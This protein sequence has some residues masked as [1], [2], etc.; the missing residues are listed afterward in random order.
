MLKI[1]NKAL[2]VFNSYYA[3]QVLFTDDTKKIKEIDKKYLHTMEVVK[4]GSSVVKSL[5]FNETFV[6]L[7]KLAF[8]NHDIG[9]FEQMLITGNYI[10]SDLVAQIGLNHGELGKQIL[11]NGLIEKEIPS[12][13]VYDEPI[14]DIVDKHVDGRFDEKDLLVLSSDLLK[15][16][17]AIEFFSRASEEE[18]AKVINTITQIVQDVDRLD[19]YHQILEGRWTPMKVDEP[20]NPKV[21]DMFYNGEYLNMVELKKQGLWNANVGELVRL[22]FVNQIRLLSVAK[23]I[24]DKNI[25]MKMKELRQNP[26]VLDAFDFMQS[27]LEEMINNS[28]GITICKKNN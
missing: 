14:L 7:S 5:D 2:Q 3:L 17:D 13:R 26:F 9:R 8:L 27:K 25:L 12:T 6:E 28:D 18:K 15:S 23:L 21:M 19:I 16:A 22:S 1:Y 4:D 11:K 24:H 10:D 20:I